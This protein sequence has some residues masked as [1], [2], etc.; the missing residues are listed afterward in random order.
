MRRIFE[1]RLARVL[2]ALLAGFMLLLANAPLIAQD[3]PND[4]PLGD[5]ARNLRKKPS[6][7][8]QV[9]DDD[10][11]P[12]VMQ[13]AEAHRSSGSAM[14][15][16]MGG[17]EKGFQVSAPDVTCSLAFSPNVKALLASNQYA[18]MDLPAEEVIKLEGPATIE[19][20]ALTVSVF[21]G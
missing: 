9:I 19:G 10:N 3:D 1:S 2:P 7:F 16:L 14:K 8:Q 11:L 4:T 15:F 5:V 13:Q 6:G 12:S 21:N 20:D 17:G 18:Q